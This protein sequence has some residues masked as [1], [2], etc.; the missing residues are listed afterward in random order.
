TFIVK[1]ASATALSAMKFIDLALDAGF[2]EGVIQYVNAS[3]STAG[4]VFT[5]SDKIMKLTFTGSTKVGKSLMSDA[6]VTVKNVTMELGGH[7]P[8]I[9][10][11]DAD[12]E[13][14]VEG[15]IASKFRNAGQTCVCTKIGR[16]SCRE[17]V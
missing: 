7:A 13:Q 15:T 14:A 12:I 3:G 8:L 4:K 17:G 10:H 2:D 16:A 6:S 1:P 9:V 11:S 5:Q